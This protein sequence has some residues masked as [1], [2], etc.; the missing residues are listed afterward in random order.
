MI[1]EHLMGIQY[2][3]MMETEIKKQRRTS[4]YAYAL[5]MYALERPASFMN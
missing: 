4:Q 2:L 1:G 3:S 5:S